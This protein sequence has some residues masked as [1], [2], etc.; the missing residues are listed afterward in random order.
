MNFPK[1]NCAT[2]YL[3]KNHF[4]KNIQLNS[5]TSPNLHLGVQCKYRTVCTVWRGFRTTGV[6]VLLFC[7]IFGKYERRLSYKVPE[8]RWSCRVLCWSSPPRGYT[9]TWCPPS[10][11]SSC[12]TIFT[13]KYYPMFFIY[14][15]A[16]LRIRIRPKNVIT[17]I[18]KIYIFLI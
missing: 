5:S 13:D 10:T 3:S 9:G 8:H 16:V 17:R 7:F 11:P 12:S 4:D 18:I 2:R 6:F 14:S 1:N 15:W